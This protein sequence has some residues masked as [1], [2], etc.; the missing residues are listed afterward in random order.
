MIGAY[1]FER[2]SIVC[3]LLWYGALSSIMMLVFRQ[4]LSLLSRWAKSL[5][6]KRQKVLE[7]VR[8]L[9]MVKATSLWVLTAAIT[10]IDESL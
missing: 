9:F 2:N 5:A 10:L 4:S 3:L 8:P 6:R 7:F 1:I